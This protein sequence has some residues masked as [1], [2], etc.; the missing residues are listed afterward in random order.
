MIQLS[1][2]VLLAFKDN[3]LVVFGNDIRNTVSRF[4][5]VVL[6]LENKTFAR[7]KQRYEY[8]KSIGWSW[9]RIL[10]YSRAKENFLRTILTRP[11]TFI[12]T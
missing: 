7:K 12:R 11:R 9:P 4:T 1:L 5:G 2:Y 6:F 3:L 10:H 8:S